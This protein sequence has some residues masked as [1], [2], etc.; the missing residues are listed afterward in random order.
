MKGKWTK[1]LPEIIF[2]YGIMYYGWGSKFG[3]PIDK[4]GIVALF[5][6]YSIFALYCFDTYEMLINEEAIRINSLFSKNTY[7]PIQDIHKIGLENHSYQIRRIY[8]LFVYTDEKI[9]KLPTHLFNKKELNPYLSKLCQEK[10][11]EYYFKK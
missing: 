10:G 5:I 7:I 8:I 6:M 3:F 1:N 11:I 9:Y 4:S 2:F